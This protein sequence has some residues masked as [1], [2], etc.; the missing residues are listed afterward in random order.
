MQS[1]KAD[2]MTPPFLPTDHRSQGKADARAPAV[3]TDS[4]PTALRRAG[5]IAQIVILAQVITLMT[6]K[7]YRAFPASYSPVA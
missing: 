4:D 7:R 6:K 3:W 1:T 2:Q 5:G